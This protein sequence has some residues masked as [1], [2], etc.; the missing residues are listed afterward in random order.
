MTSGFVGG[1][2]EGFVGGYGAGSAGGP[3][4]GWFDSFVRGIVNSVG[5]SGHL[6]EYLFLWPFP[7][8]GLFFT[9]STQVSFSFV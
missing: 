6:P 2:G 1:Y 9:Q 5:L 7:A 3:V 4:G 8:F